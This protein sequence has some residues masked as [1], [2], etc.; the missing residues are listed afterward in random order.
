MESL[1]FFFA[2]RHGAC[3]SSLEGQRALA[4]QFEAF[5]STPCLEQ[6]VLV[7]DAPG[8]F[9][10]EG[11]RSVRLIAAASPRLSKHS[12][13]WAEALHA[14]KTAVPLM[15]PGGKRTLVA[16]MRNVH[17][18]P[19]IMCGALAFHD[20]SGKDLTTSAVT[21]A[22][23]PC[24]MRTG[25]R[26]LDAGHLILFETDPHNVLEGFPSERAVLTRAFTHLWDS[27]P[28]DGRMFQKMS[29]EGFAPDGLWAQAPWAG[30]PAG[31]HWLWEGPETARLV[32]QRDAL[33]AWNKAASSGMTLIGA[34]LVKAPDDPHVALA[35]SASGEHFLAASLHHGGMRQ[36]ALFR[37]FPL[38]AQGCGK[39][40]YQTLTL[41]EDNPAGSI[42]IASREISGFLYYIEEQ[43]EVA[44]AERFVPYGIEADIWNWNEKEGLAVNATTGEPITG[45]QQF[46][47][48][49]EI[50]ASLLVA[51]PETFRELEKVLQDPS[52]QAFYPVPGGVF[53]DDRLT[54]AARWAVKETL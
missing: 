20:A 30:M 35:Q 7:T 8:L 3:W 15:G 10:F 33:A 1:I 52:R 51:T 39:K 28:P 24:Q 16:N 48:V 50:D 32:C 13:P 53:C 46:P 12:P 11:A 9:T 2:G 17:L 45:R 41:D 23:H 44:D 38:T 36:P 18:T 34:N 43:A 25:V 40:D 21:P 29:R 27:L 5:L 37:L 42:F 31:L 22:D 47:P 19:E 4:E 54:L 6:T 14:V 49:M 26:L